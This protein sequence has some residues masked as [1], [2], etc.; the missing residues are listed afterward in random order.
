MAGPDQFEKAS[1]DGTSLGNILLELGYVTEE[2]LEEAIRIQKSQS[3][4][5]SI[6][7]DQ[8][9]AIT[10]SQLEEALLEQK[11]R[12]NK[13]NLREITKF[14]AVKQNQLV[15][16]VAE[17]FRNLATKFDQVSFKVAGK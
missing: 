3:M 4:L 16:E 12:R 13:A 1:R 17:G 10:M 6:L 2:D 9:K 5:G 7:V 14:Q 15:T 8:M 11:I